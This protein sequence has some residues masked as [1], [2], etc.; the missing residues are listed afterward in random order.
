MP[1][2]DEE[3]TSLDKKLYRYLV[4]NDFTEQYWKTVDAAREFNVSESDVYESLS[5]LAKLKK[6][7]VWIYYKDGRIRIA[8]E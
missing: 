5:R 8:A 2:A 4:D 3:L 7:N 6:D 1:M